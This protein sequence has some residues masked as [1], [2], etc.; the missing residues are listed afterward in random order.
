ACADDQRIDNTFWANGAEKQRDV[1]RAGAG[2]SADPATWPKNQTTTWTHFDNGLLRNLETVNGSGTVTE[3][4]QVGYLD[5][6]GVFVDG[7]RTTDQYVLKRA[8][9]NTA[10]TC[11]AGAPCDAKYSYD[12]RDRVVSHQLRAGKTNT[13][14]LDQPANL[15]G[16]TSVR[17]GAITTQVENGTTSTRKYTS[18]QLTEQ[19]TGGATG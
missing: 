14:T 12:A 3:S 8:E 15:L 13:Y 17:T 19:T 11:V 4:H 6:A 9:G 1:Y 2:C 18:G 5:D 10:S 7:H 16:D